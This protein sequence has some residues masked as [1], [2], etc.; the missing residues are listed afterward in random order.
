MK[1]ESQ[2]T[3]SQPVSE[4]IPGNEPKED[5][6]YQVT[7]DVGQFGVL[8]LYFTK[9]TGWSETYS[10]IAYKK[11]NLSK[12]YQAPEPEPELLCPA[13]GQLGEMQRYIEGHRFECIIS[14]CMFRTALQDNK[15]LALGNRT[16][17][18]EALNRRKNNADTKLY[19]DN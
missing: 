7:F 1:T 4:W 12:P 17:I 18:Y 11:I 9:G 14:V 13:C 5:G 19:N 15:E 6:W 2:V 8:P 16:I 3:W 10:V